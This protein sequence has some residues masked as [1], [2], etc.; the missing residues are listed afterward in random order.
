[1]NKS[2]SERISGHL[3][4]HGL[5]FTEKRG[6]ADLVIIN[7]CGV[8]QSAEDRIY[9]LVPK[10]KKENKKVKI[11]IA[12]CL[13]QRKDVQKRLEGRVDF[14]LPIVELPKLAKKL[15]LDYKKSEYDYLKIKA[16]YNSK[17]SAFVPIGN[18]CNN[19]CAYCVVPYARGREKYRKVEDII[20]EVKN[21]VSRGYKEINLIAQN[22]NSY[23]CGKT[24]FSDLLKKV[25]E[26]EGEFWIRFATSHPK[27]M[28]DKLIRTISECDKVC[29]HIHLPAQAGDN[30]VLK[31]MN[32][33]YTVGHYKKLIN[34]I[35][36]LIPNASIS[37][38]TIVGF[39]GETEKQFN[40][41]KKLYREVKYDLA[42]IAQYSPRYGT[43]AY[44]LNDDI[45]KEEKKRREEELMKILR[46]TALENNKK[47]LG[48][49]VSVLVEGRG[50]N[51]EYFGKTRTYKNVK[52]KSN[53]NENL[54]GQ[55]AKVKIKKAFD[56]GLEGELI[57]N[58]ALVILG[59]TSSGK[60]GVAVKLANKYN[61]EII[62]A[63]SRQVYRGMDV[64]TGKD[65]EEYI[66]GKKKI[67]YHLIDV[68]NPKEEFNLAEYVKLASIAIEDILNRG[69]L[70]IIAGGT[71]LYLQALVDGYNL[72]EV[73]PDK[74]LRASL[75]KLSTE[76]LLKKLKKLDK[77]FVENLNN[78]EKNNKRRLIRYIE[79]KSQNSKFKIQKIKNNDYNFLLIGL[80]LERG[81]LNKRIYKRLID[82][83]EKEGMID[84]VKRLHKQGVSWKRL[85][86]FGLEYKHVSWFLQEKIEYEEMI[87]KLNIAIRQFAKRQM[88][89]FKRWEKILRQT[90]DKRRKINWIKNKKD[91]D[92]LLNNFFK[93]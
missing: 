36:K 15:G 11:I 18:G 88:T 78:S 79:V 23:K 63:D 85:E 86:S 5:S 27:D 84:E 51:G 48:K 12:G 10:I 71:G 35:R 47:Y 30:V 80:D 40:N 73:K 4:D 75:E 69:K 25:N 29:E 64:G 9:G 19:F 14:W 82:R 46:K 1:M 44:K 65:L 26:L 2:D 77:G 70:P 56:F 38:D 20:K 32:R 49:I 89:W 37:T 8:R 34:K 92:K 53:T 67:T 42:Y 24:D 54:I 55:F 22:V 91:I 41:T 72:S 6:E 76:E 66:I 58:K 13:S 39:P 16:K 81:E 83:I 59:P 21:L 31:N 33:K 60:T 3:E 7:T 61:G 57:S 90:Q 52:I 74:K 43:A 28:S 68:V 93:G 17:I 62:S 87:E 50:K 45:S